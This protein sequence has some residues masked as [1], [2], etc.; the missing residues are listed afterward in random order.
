L[1]WRFNMDVIVASYVIGMIT[2]I[3][4]AKT[5]KKIIGE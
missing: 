3:V 4:I 1:W 2:G 5:I